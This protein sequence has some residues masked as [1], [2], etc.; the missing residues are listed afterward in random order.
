MR[1]KGYSSD[2]RTSFYPPK[3]AI[4]LKISGAISAHIF[5]QGDTERK[6]GIAEIAPVETGWL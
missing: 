5:G 6:V 1:H 2:K 4:V 3:D